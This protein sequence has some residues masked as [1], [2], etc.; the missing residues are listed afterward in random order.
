MCNFFKDLK[1]ELYNDAKK[2]YIKLGF[3]VALF[4]ADLAA[5]AWFIQIV[6]GGG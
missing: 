1:R 2:H 6:K 3:Y 5:I 4:S